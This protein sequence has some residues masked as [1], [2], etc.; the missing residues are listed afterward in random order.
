MANAHA[1]IID[2]NMESIEVLARLLA[3]NDV[4]HTA[5]QDTSEVENVLQHMPEVDVIFLDLEMP[6]RNGYEIFEILRHNLGNV[7]PIVACTVH[8]NEIATTREVGFNGFI[9]K[10]LDPKV[11]ARHLSQILNGKAVWDAS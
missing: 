9:A 8:S 3:A 2:D 1:L 10:P 6:K 5:V 11:F 4:T 7:A